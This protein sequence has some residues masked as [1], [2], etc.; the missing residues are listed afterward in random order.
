MIIPRPFS[1]IYHSQNDWLS[2]RFHFS[3]DDY[4]DPLQVHWGI[5]RVLNDD[6]INANKGFGMHGHNDMEILTFMIEGELTHGDSLGHKEKLKAGEIQYMSAGSGIVH[7]EMNESNAEVHLAQIWILPEKKGHTPKYAQMNYAHLDRTNKWVHLTSHESSPEPE[8]LPIRSQAVLS[9][10]K[11]AKG[12]IL[13]L[14]SLGKS[15]LFV[16]SG[17]VQL[18]DYRLRARDGCKIDK[19]SL[20]LQADSDAE[21]M[22]L[23]NL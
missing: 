23:N 5:L 8:T 3:F 15:Y 22:W 7:S 21:L 20:K 10:A 11:L 2:S 1:E 12:A 4:Y 16:I 14:E 9:T 17:E 13:P 6:Q 18:G 19:E